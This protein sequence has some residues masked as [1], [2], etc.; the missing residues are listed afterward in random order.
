MI[1]TRRSNR[2]IGTALAA[3]MFATFLAPQA[4]DAKGKGKAKTSKTATGHAFPSKAPK[5]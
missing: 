5:K 3:A 2:F 1:D 4:A